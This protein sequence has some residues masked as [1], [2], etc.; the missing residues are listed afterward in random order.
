MGRKVSTPNDM[1]RQ[2]DEQ[3]ATDGAQADFVIFLDGIEK[4]NRA[5]ESSLEHFRKSWH[6]PNWHILI[7]K[8]PEESKGSMGSRLNN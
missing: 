3:Y 4:E 2:F 8:A 6:R 1:V 5:V 7:Q